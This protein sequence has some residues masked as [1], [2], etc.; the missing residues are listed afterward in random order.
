MFLTNLPHTLLYPHY[1]RAF[2][3]GLACKWIIR[4][5]WV[6]SAKKPKT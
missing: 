3:F 2:L 5:W 6:R 1:A 4:F